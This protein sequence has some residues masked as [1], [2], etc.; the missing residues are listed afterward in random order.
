MGIEGQLTIDLYRNGNGSCRAEIASTRPVDIA[1]LFHGKTASETLATVPL[2]FSICAKAQAA[3]CVAALEQAS[4]LDAPQATRLARQMVVLA[5][6]AREHVLRIALDWP[7]FAGS[8]APPLDARVMMRFVGDVQQALFGAGDAFALSAQPEPD[9]ETASRLISEFAAFL[10][11]GI[12]GEPLEVWLQRGSVDDVNSWAARGETVAV[13][14][15]HEVTAKGWAGAGAAAESFL[16]NVPDA[17]LL[18]GGG[19]LAAPAAWDSAPL[20]TSCLSR[21]AGRGAVAALR[22]QYGTGLLTRLTA[23]LTELAL[24]PGQLTELLEQIPEELGN[25]ERPPKDAAN[26]AGAAQVEAARGRLVHMARLRGGVV[27][28]YRILAPTEWN[29]HPQGP[30]A[31]SLS[32][33]AGADEAVLKAQAGLLVNAIDPCVGYEVRVV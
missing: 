18:N 3:A 4:G 31:Q 25:P 10:E 29:F 22:A 24:L 12:F 6:T 30:A 9:Q 1:R 17:A 2:L 13:R 32:R 28:N 26:G 8:D 19:P 16:P 11:T 7:G 20:E 21:Q 5:E 15:V 23:R 14:L 27:A 33:L